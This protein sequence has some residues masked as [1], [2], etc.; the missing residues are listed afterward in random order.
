MSHFRRLSACGGLAAFAAPL[1]L[2][3]C[4][5]TAHADQ[6]PFPGKGYVSVG[7]PAE[8]G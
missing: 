7:G 3:G 5:G 8:P 1:F 6:L 4:A 2:L